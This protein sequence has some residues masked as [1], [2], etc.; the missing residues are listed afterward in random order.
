MF[1]FAL[2]A[3]AGAAV[4]EAASW[5]AYARGGWPVWAWAALACAVLLTNARLRGI[6]G[7][8]LVLAGAAAG[9]ACAV[10]QGAWWMAAVASATGPGSPCRWEGVVVR[11]PEADE[12]GATLVVRLDGRRWRGG[13]VRVT[14]PPDTPLPEMGRRVRFGA[15]L[16]APGTEGV[17]GRVAARR[18]EVGS[19]RAWGYEAR[20]WRPGGVG[21]LLRWRSATTRAVARIRGPGGDLLT[22]VLVGDRRRVAET[23]LEEDFRLLGLSHVLAVSGDQLGLACAGA[24]LVLRRLRVPRKAQ[25]A[26]GVVVGGCFTVVTGLQVPTLRALLMVVIVALAAMLGRRSDPLAALA[27]AV[28][29]MVVADPRCVHDVGFRLSV[30][31]VG[32]LVLL[33]GLVSAWARCAAPP[34]LAGVSTVAA[35]TLLA[36]TASLP[37]AA[38]VF[39]M[40]SVAAPLA[41]VM[42]LPLVPVALWVATP[43]ALVRPLA[44]A[45]GDWLLRCAAAVLRFAATLADAVAGLPGAAVPLDVTSSVC[46]AVVG[47]V[48]V[49]AWWLWPPPTPRRARAAAGAALSVSLLLALGPPVPRSATL[50]AMDVGQG[51]ALLVRDRGRSLLVDCGPNETSLRKALARQG[52]RRLDGVVLTHPHDDHTGG[53]GALSMLRVG[54]VGVPSFCEDAFAR[55]RG[56]AARMPAPPRWLRLAAGQRFVLG[57]TSLRVVWP[58]KAPAS[59]LSANDGSVVLLLERGE[60]GILLTGDIEQPA[61]GE[62]PAIG[63][64]DVLKVPHHGSSNGIAEDSAR[65][66]RPALALVSVGADNRFGHP[67]PSALQLLRRA[68]STVRRTDLQGDLTVTT[69]RRGIVLSCSRRPSRAP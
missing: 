13:S 61:Q 64:V 20:G 60:T 62:M 56:V 22:G 12:R 35:C 69:G 46:A 8:G 43:G 55:Q 17:R 41:N 52:V 63:R 9:L 1:W 23:P 49:A 5:A 30:C 53:F 16:R 50:V 31:A 15:R 45:V 54:W 51:D 32:S 68:G 14:L 25:A 39:G 18:G 28:T 26:C 24:L 33:G 34:R 40:V 65:Q 4:G 27:V 37:V 67:S 48:F 38:P 66:W 2:S 44:P 7:A 29:V 6:S 58:P 36:Q 21:K 57:S 42:V 3:C 47:T 59:E 11:D 10:A 19:G